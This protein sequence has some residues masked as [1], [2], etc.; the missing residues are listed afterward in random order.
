MEFRNHF[1]VDKLRVV[2]PSLRVQTNPIY[3]KPSPF[4]SIM[5]LLK[6]GPHLHNF[7][8]DFFVDKEKREFRFERCIQMGFFPINGFKESL[9]MDFF[10]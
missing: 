7:V 9:R 2:P 1:L 5:R 6:L 4:Y 3:K 8:F 10:L